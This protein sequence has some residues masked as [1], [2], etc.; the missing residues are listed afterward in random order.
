MICRLCAAEAPFLC[1]Q[2]VLSRIEVSYFQCPGCDLIQTEAPHWLE[3]AYS[4]AFSALDTGAIARN[5]ISAR[6]TRAVAF[7]LGLDA[8][9]RGLDYGGGHG[10]LVRMLRDLGLD[11]RW[12]DPR[13]ENL[14]AR[15]FEGNPAE[16][17]ELVTAFEVLEH[18]ANARLELEKIFAP[19]PRAVLVGTLLHQGHQ[20]GWWYYT[21]ETGQHVSFYS[22]RTMEYLGALFGYQV[23]AS[24]AQTLFVRRKPAL[25][26][27]RRALLARVAQPGLLEAL[28]ALLPEPLV[29]HLLPYRPLAEA[30]HLALKG[31]AS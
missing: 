11:F 20:D 4:S 31:K 15:G 28:G 21:L 9:A 25:G 6:R 16:K 23:F 27:V 3:E 19:G 2:R 18:L 29:T 30:D 13:A 12:F 17:F 7:A 1:K 5:Q 22:R 26:R 24:S 10:V 8:G 14:Y